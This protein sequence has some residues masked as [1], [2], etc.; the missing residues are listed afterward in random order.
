MSGQPDIGE[1][2]GM[3]ATFDDIKQQFH[4]EQI[5][6]IDRPDQLV[7]IKHE[8]AIANSFNEMHRM[9]MSEEVYQQIKSYLS[10]IHEAI[11]V[12]VDALRPV[13]PR[14]LAAE[15]AAHGAQQQQVRKHINEGGESPLPA[16]IANKENKPEEPTPTSSAP[17]PKM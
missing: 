1:E 8:L 6:Q 11:D 4:P 5:R 14:E 9:D 13:K 16:P 12:Q 10:E 3:P 15:A 17:A 7:I 2:T